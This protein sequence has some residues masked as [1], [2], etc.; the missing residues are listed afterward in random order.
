LNN[1][2]KRFLKLGEIGVPFAL[3]IRAV[4]TPQDTLFRNALFE[5]A[6]YAKLEHFI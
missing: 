1:R 3:K 2:T 6:I 4:F 5:M